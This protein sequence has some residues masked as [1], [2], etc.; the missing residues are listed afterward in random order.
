MFAAQATVADPDRFNR[1][2][3]ELSIKVLDRVVPEEV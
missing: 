1:D 3:V 2:P